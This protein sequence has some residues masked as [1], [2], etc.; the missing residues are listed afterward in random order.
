[1]TYMD[2]GTY[3]AKRVSW[4]ESYRKL[5][6]RIIAADPDA[7]DWFAEFRR[8][9]V[10]DEDMLTSAL[11]YAYVNGLLALNKPEKL[12]KD[13]SAKT[14]RRAAIA[15]TAKEVEAVAIQVQKQ[16]LL[17]L[18]MVN[19]KRLGD[20][21]GAE[22]RTFEGWLARIAKLVPPR[23]KVSDVLS[24]ARVAALWKQSQK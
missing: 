20:C 15:A 2:E 22:C 4:E 16:L 21:T 8:Q 23:K 3:G 10:D 14:D 7:G 9:C 13:K 18:I 1:M 12:T 17:N 19:G 6:R 5:L 24:E 11:K